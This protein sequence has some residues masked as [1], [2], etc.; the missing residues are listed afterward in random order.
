VAAS[1]PA[2]QYIVSRLGVCDASNMLRRGTLREFACRRIAMCSML[3]LALSIKLGVRLR[4]PLMLRLPDP[5]TD[6]RHRHDL[7]RSCCPSKG[8]LKFGNGFIHWVYYPG[9]LIAVPR[10]P[11]HID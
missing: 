10:I 8:Q 7:S 11:I 1:M 2:W 3:H 4:A 6:T 9:L 5:P